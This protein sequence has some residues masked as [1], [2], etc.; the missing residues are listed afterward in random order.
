M[1]TNAAA[2]PSVDEVSDFLALLADSGLADQ[3]GSWVSDQVGNQP[4]TGA[5]LLAVLDADTGPP[6]RQSPA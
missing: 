5:Q 3:A 4:V 6:P 1:T 2:Q